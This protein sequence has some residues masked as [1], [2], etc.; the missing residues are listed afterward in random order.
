MN[1]IQHPLLIALAWALIL[2]SPPKAAQH[3]SCWPHCHFPAPRL[4]AWVSEWREDSLGK[5][6][7]QNGVWGSSFFIHWLTG[8]LR[9]RANGSTKFSDPQLKA[10]RRTLFF[11]KALRHVNSWTFDFLLNRNM[12][13]FCWLF[14][15]ASPRMQ[16]PIF[17][18]CF[19][20]YFTLSHFLSL[21]EWT[22]LLHQYLELK[23]TE[24]SFC[25]RAPPH[26]RIV[27]DIFQD[28]LTRKPLPSPPQLKE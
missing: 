9:K 5:V 11:G 2:P 14:R 21:L 20:F 28:L 27:T 17:V 25:L 6:T 19:T 4:H 3:L 7:L 23:N 26:V 24:A 18:L 1:P 15:K 22:I 12:R 13:K 8:V 16:M 10:G